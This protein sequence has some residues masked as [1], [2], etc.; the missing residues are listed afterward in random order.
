MA[1]SH[2]AYRSAY[3]SIYSFFRAIRQRRPPE[4]AQ[5]PSKP[6]R[7][8]R[9]AFIH[10]ERKVKTG[11]HQINDLMARGLRAT[12]VAV[13]NFYPRAELINA[14]QHLRGIANVLFFY[15]LLEQ[16][17]EILRYD[18]IQGTT[19]TP[20]PFLAF[21]AAVVS[22]FGST[23]QGFLDSTPVANNLPSETRSVWY[24]LRREGAIAELNIKTRRPLRDIADMEQ[25]VA[26][27]ATAAIATSEHVRTE[28][29]QMGVAPERIFVVP[30]AIEDYWFSNE[31]RGKRPPGLVFLGRLGADAF[32]LT[33]K[34]LD[35]LVQVYEKFPELPK[36][37]IAITTNKKLT[38]WL[39]KIPR[40]ELFINMR[41]D[42]IP[43]V[44]AAR[45]GSIAFIPSRYEGFS[46][47]LI[48]CMSQGLVPIT[49]AVGV[50]PEVIRNG[51]NGFI[52]S[53]QAEAIARIHELMDDPILRDR[54]AHAAKRSAEPYRT[55]AVI[56]QLVEAY[57][58]IRAL[59]PRS[60]NGKPVP[61]SV[62]P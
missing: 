25:Y 38:A 51:E 30:N 31:V 41:K 42:Y 4:S 48:E 22:H 54:L 28:L 10:N 36:T 40:H 46:L 24:R 49:Y 17:S 32:T 29:S 39:K 12:G 44:L 11:A 20:L 59:P 52:V 56:P 43:G 2:S 6:A 37:T 47:S 5:R 53:S 34:G 13:K 23:T 61:T 35:R 7:G 27:S 19:Y 14:P 55:T 15:S 58:R 3:R 33:L 60:I 8:I 1:A 45:F 18:L 62:Y 21:D 26:T 50:A 9:V 57:T 16:R